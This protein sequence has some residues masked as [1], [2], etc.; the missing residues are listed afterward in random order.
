VTGNPSPSFAHQAHVYRSPQQ[1]VREAAPFVREGLEAGDPVLAATA[2]ANVEALRLELGDEAEGVSLHDT[3]EWFP[4]PY[5]RLQAI[6]R[7]IDELPPGRTLRALAEPIW[8]GS[9]AVVREWARYESVLN[10]ALSGARTRVICLNDGSALPDPVLEYATH[11]HPE[12]VQDGAAIL[13]PS[14]VPPEQFSAGE[15]PSPPRNAI[16]FELDVDGPGLRDAVGDFA[17]GQGFPR[18]RIDDFVLAVWEVARAVIDDGQPP[19]G[20]QIWASDEELVC[21][22]SNH[23]PGAT[24]RL[25]GWV[26]PASPDERGWELAIARQLA[27]AM[28]IVPTKLGTSISLYLS[29]IPQTTI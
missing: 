4:D 20:A 1:F 26:P 2:P 8:S 16:E 3:H 22:V 6:N 17:L 7:L 19:Y 15:S 12:Q 21:E 18:E 13:C 27:D 23:G 14:Y 11:T 29:R 28:E 10:Q 9:P 24:D 25:A 5:A